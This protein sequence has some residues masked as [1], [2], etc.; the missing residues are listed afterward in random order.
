[1]P[2]RERRR[3]RRRRQR[4]VGGQ[5]GRGR[6]AAGEQRLAHRVRAAAGQRDGEETTRRGLA[7]GAAAQRQCARDGEPQDAVVGRGG[8][9][10]HHRV[11]PAG[12]IVAMWREMPRSI[13]LTGSTSRRSRFTADHIDGPSLGA[14]GLT[15]RD[16]TG[17]KRPLTEVPSRARAPLRL[18]GMQRRILGIETEFGIT[19][20]FHGQRRLSPDEVARYLFRR[21]VSWGRSSNVF[22]RNGSRLYLDVG[23][24]PE[25]ATAECDSL[26]SW[27]RTTRPASGSCRTWWSTPRRG[28]SKRASAATS[29]CSRTTPTPPATPTA[30]TR[31]S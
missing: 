18:V 24:H 2:R 10:L 25:Y 16:V 4:L 28:W 5:L 12:G 31:T 22:L 21:V 7:R 23:T 13:S 29:T 19:C 1:M 15:L 17:G 27:S 9:A 20:T 6:A 3:G 8:E 30:A 11:E 26:P 14:D